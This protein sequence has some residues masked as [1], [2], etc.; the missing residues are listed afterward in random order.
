[1]SLSVDDTSEEGALVFAESDKTST[2]ADVKVELDDGL[3]TVQR[4]EIGCPAPIEH[5]RH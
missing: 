1:M 2:A 5:D 3:G 4:R